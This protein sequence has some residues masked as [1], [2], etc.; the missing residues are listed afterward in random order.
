MV[1]RWR[2]IGIDPAPSK[3]CVAYSE[4]V[5]DEIAP[6]AL[7]A[8]VADA[9]AA[10]QSTLVAWDAP[11]SYDRAN[12]SDR[13]IDKAARRWVKRQVNAGRFDPKAVHALPFSGVPHWAVTCDALGLP[14]CF[15]PGGLQLAST[16][17]S[18]GP[19]AIEVHP[20]VALGAWWI[21]AK[22][23][24]PMPRY[25]QD[26]VACARIA[27][28]LDFPS[29]A[30][31]SDDTLDAYVAHRLGELFLVG[32]ALWVGSPRIGGYVMPRCDA[33]TDLLD[34]LSEL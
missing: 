28:V 29:G 30:S 10:S 9:I 19:A 8:Y 31:A 33:T 23:S 17:P 14:F 2:V 21:E 25:K 32:D 5:W 15:P 20:A 24:E 3:A 22:C 34:V 4:G 11:L 26:P 1:N 6:S 7:R 13:V 12:Q 18:D 27:S 16:V